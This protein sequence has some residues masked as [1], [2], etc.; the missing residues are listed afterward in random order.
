M[1][2]VFVE[3][4]EDELSQQAVKFARGLG[5]DVDPVSID[6]SDYAPAAWATRPPPGGK[7]S[8]S[9]ALK[10]KRHRRPSRPRA[11]H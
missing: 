5:A 4:A 10:L 2:L 1:T 7:K 11:G 3:N 9:G 6:D 8:S